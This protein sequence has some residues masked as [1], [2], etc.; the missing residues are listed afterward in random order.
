M[1]LRERAC[2]G[3]GSPLLHCAPRRERHA[4]HRRASEQQID[5]DEQTERR[6]EAAGGV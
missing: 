6:R 1:S 2:L 3:L 5:A 4:D